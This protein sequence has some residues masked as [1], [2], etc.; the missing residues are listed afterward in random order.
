MPKKRSSYLARNVACLFAILCCAAALFLRFGT[1]EGLFSDPLS[2]GETEIHQ[3]DIGQGDATLIR[4]AES[5]VLIDAGDNGYGDTVVRYLLSQHI[6]SLDLVIATHPHAD[7]IGGMRDVLEKFEVKQILM[8][9]L[10]ANLIPTSTTYEK[11]IAMIAEKGMFLEKAEPGKTVALPDCSIEI[12]APVGKYQDL[13]NYSIAG[14]LVSG[15]FR[16]FFGG[17]MEKE[18]EE[19][20]LALNPDLKADVQK[21]SHHGSDTS[22]TAAMLD[23]VGAKVALISVGKGNSYGH[24]HEDVL[25]RLEERGIKYYRTDQAGNIV[26]N[27]K[28]GEITVE[29]SR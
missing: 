20:L 11:L 6:K 21:I 29:T 25:E 22:N 12:L 13:N 26:V 3:I 2:P 19:D 27:W 16:Y 24:P 10:P 1:K 8:P 17:D 5:T 14:R 18:A 4:T 28:N 15:E 9:E 23:A 7:H